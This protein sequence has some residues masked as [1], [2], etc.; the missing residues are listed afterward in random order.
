[1]ALT[2]NVGAYNSEV[3]RSGFESVPKGQREAAK[4]LG[5]S[6]WVTFSVVVF[7]QALRVAIPP[8]VNNLVALLKDSSLASVIGLLELSMAGQRVS[9]ETFQP[10]PVLGTVAFL[11]LTLTTILTFFTWWFEKSFMKKFG[12]KKVTV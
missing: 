2:L 5:L 9:S 11:Y 1:M 6:N 3:F 4:S 7:P 12:I 10:V 8:L